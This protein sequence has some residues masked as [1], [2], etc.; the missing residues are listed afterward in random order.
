M[1]RLALLIAAAALSLA[2]PDSKVIIPVEGVSCASCTLAVRRALKK[3][4]GVKRI[5][6]GAHQNE[7]VITYDAS[8]VKPEQMVKAID[9]LGFKAGT[10]VKG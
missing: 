6:P 2:S 4:E 5:E 9:D 8:K 3:M 10:P 1:P 7:A